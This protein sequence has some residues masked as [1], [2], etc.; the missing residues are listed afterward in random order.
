MTERTGTAGLQGNE[1]GEMPQ[2]PNCKRTVPDGRHVICPHCRC[3]TWCDRLV[4]LGETGSLDNIVRLALACARERER[5][6][7]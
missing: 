3:L 2:C 1:T 7:Q 6:T 5:M 4:I